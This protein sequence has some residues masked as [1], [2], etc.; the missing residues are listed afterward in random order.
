METLHI[1]S[2]VDEIGIPTRAEG[3]D[4]AYD[5]ML[6][7]SCYHDPIFATLQDDYHSSQAN[8]VHME[9][10][11]CTSTPDLYFQ[12]RKFIH[13]GCNY[14]RIRQ[15]QIDIL[16]E[17]RDDLS[18][19]R[20]EVENGGMPYP[21][22]QLSNFEPHYISTLITAFHKFHQNQRSLDSF[23]PMQTIGKYE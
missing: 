3:V 8:G 7:H 19:M 23:N 4:R 9:W 5:F 13:D 16:Q 11:N 12:L 20:L 21:S 2:L 6:S 14:I 17:L 1:I 15:I 10:T 22:P 18:S